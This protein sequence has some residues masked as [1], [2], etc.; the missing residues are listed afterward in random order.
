MGPNLIGILVSL[1]SVWNILGPVGEVFVSE[2]IADFGDF[3]GFLISEVLACLAITQAIM[4]IGCLLCAYAIFGYLRRRFCIPNARRS[5]LSRKISSETC[6]YYFETSLVANIAT[7]V[8]S[9]LLANTLW[10]RKLQNCVP[11]TYGPIIP[12]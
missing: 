10:Y 4:G 11:H 7:T 9:L 5:L 1:L 8:E 6:R 3:G 12:L 2:Y